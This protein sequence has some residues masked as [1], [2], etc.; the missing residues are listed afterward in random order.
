MLRTLPPAAHPRY[1]QT[2]SGQNSDVSLVVFCFLLLFIS[3]D[4]S[5]TKPSFPAAPVGVQLAPPTVTQLTATHS[6][7]Q[8]RVVPFVKR[9]VAESPPTRANKQPSVIVP[10]FHVLVFSE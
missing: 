6:G 1:Q 4:R 2:D 5:Q 9:R 3:R 7:I 8:S 10:S